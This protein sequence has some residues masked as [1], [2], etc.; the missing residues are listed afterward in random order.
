[1]NQSPIRETGN[2][3]VEVRNLDSIPSVLGRKGTQ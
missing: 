3:L 2:H 1:M